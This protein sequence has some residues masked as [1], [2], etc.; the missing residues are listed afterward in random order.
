MGPSAL[1]DFLFNTPKKTFG[2]LFAFSCGMMLVALFMEHYLLLKPC[3]LCYMQRGAVILIAFIALIG[4][5]INLDNI[6]TYKG[7]LIA[8]FISILA[9][10]ALSTRQLYLQSLPP[11]LVPSCAPDLDYLL[12]T[13]P[14]LEIFWM[15]ISGDGN[16]AE[17]LWS[18]LGISIP[19]WLLIGFLIALF[20]VSKVFVSANEIHSHK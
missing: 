3:M 18:F 10:I 16:C 17:V 9:G 20:Y 7:F 15:A 4:Y 19:G 8:I 6:K 13:L 1:I 14:F 5:L 12:E 11:E 2:I